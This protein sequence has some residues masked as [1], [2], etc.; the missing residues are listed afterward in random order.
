MSKRLMLRIIIILILYNSRIAFY[1]NLYKTDIMKTKTLVMAS[2]MIAAT[3]A[4][5]LAP[6]FSSTALAAR[7][8]VNPG[9]ECVGTHN[10]NGNPV[11][12][13][14]INGN[15]ASTTTF[16]KVHGKFVPESTTDDNDSCADG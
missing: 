12:C 4:L 7:G 11:D 1:L 6:T 2:V 9:E 15:S 16:C 8:G 5:A 3:A 13:D 14:D 10:G